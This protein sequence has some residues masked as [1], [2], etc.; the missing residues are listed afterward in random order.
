[1]GIVLCSTDSFIWVC[2]SVRWAGRQRQRVFV[3][4]NKQAEDKHMDVRCMRGQSKSH[5]SSDN[6]LQMSY[7]YPCRTDDVS[8]VGME[9]RHLYRSAPNLMVP[10]MPWSCCILRTHAQC[11]AQKDRHPVVS[12]LSEHTRLKP[13]ER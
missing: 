6:R 7:T 4:L 8:I 12:F 9:Q 1:V 3:M 5:A 10:L 11:H 13:I 2:L